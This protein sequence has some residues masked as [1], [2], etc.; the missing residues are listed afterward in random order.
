MRSGVYSI[1]THHYI[2][3]KVFDIEN[4]FRTFVQ[5]VSARCTDVAHKWERCTAVGT[6]FDP[7]T[8]LFY[9]IVFAADYI[10]LFAYYIRWYGD[11]IFNMFKFVA[12]KDTIFAQKGNLCT[13]MWTSTGIV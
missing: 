11:R 3:V 2:A 13:A 9:T 10:C 1:E 6:V 4:V 5:N 8:S 12:A 7:V